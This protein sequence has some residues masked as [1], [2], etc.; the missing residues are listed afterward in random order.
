MSIAINDVLAG[1]LDLAEVIDP[2]RPNPSPVTPGEILL[3][4]FMRPL[5]LSTRGLAAALRVPPNRISDIVRGRRTITAGTA[6]RLARYFG[7]SPQLWLN[8]QTNYELHRALDT[9]GA[10]V[11][12]DVQPRPRA[13]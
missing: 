3:E 7:T 11:E 6:L 10:A 4:E 1:K 13:A 9:E 2:G 8:L 5:G 12:R